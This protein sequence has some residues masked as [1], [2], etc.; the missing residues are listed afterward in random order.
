[1]T[2][3]A[4]IGRVFFQPSVL[5]ISRPMTSNRGS[6]HGSAWRALQRELGAGHCVAA[7]E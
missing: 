4:A 1:M 7:N 5:P 2:L 6:I 3:I